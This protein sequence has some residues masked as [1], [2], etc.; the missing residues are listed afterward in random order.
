MGIGK[1]KANR[2]FRVI[3]RE[4]L[5]YDARLWKDAW[6]NTHDSLARGW[7]LSLAISIATLLAGMIISAG[8]STIQLTNFAVGCAALLMVGLVFFTWNLGLAP[9]RIY[10][11]LLD[12]NKKLE[13]VLRIVFRDEP[14]FNHATHSPVPGGSVRMTYVRV[15]PESLGGVVP[16]CRGY[17]TNIERLTD[18]GQWEATDFTGADSLLLS[19]SLKG[20]AGF[21]PVELRAGMKQYL[22]V[23]SANEVH[24]RIDFCTNG[25]P[26]W[27]RHVVNERGTYR[28]TVLVHGTAIAPASIFLIVTWKG[29]WDDID[30]TEGTDPNP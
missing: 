30:V 28:L 7:L 25:F 24:E 4:I 10:K 27:L 6:R 14:A 20:D 23:F 2:G 18:T 11:L 12:D 29:R 8:G 9:Y 1:V 16:E 3:I 19:W 26:N 15:L 13:P 5:C 17:L 21:E 22:D